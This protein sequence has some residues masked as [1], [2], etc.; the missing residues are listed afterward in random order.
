MATFYKSSS[1]RYGFAISSQEKK[2]FAKTMR[3]EQTPAEE[4][5]WNALKRRRY[6]K[7]LGV[8]FHRQVIILG[9][10]V[11][12]WCPSAN[13]AIECDGHLHNK[14]YDQLRDNRLKSIGIKV[15]RFSNNQVLEDL[16]SVLDS[17]KSFL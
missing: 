8:R 6:I 15:L 2:A 11:D 3:K 9:Y 12:F 13:L 17:T 14:Q 5:L 1:C 16:P 7:P 10:I 4:S